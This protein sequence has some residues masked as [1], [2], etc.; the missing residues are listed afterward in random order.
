MFNVH[1]IMKETLC[2]HENDSGAFQYYF[3][4]KTDGY[5]NSKQTD[6][7]TCVTPN[8]KI[9]LKPYLDQDTSK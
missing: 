3:Q 1:L 9:I 4:W 7:C 8:L 5:D 6:T 2:C